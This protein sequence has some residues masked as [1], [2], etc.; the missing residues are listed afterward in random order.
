MADPH[1]WFAYPWWV[2]DSKAPDYARTVDIHRK[3]GY[4]PCELFM[5]PRVRFPA[6]EVGKFLIRKKLGFRSLLEVIPTDASLVKGSHGR[7]P[8]DEADWPI[9]VGQGVEKWGTKMLSTDV[10]S[11]LKDQA[12][13]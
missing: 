5:D 10:F 4:D 9:L 1:S 8:E 6:W 11:Y 3:P 2:E 13:M 12:E 7:I